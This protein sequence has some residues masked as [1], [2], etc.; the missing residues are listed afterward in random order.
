MF[1]LHIK[2]FEYLWLGNLSQ[3]EVSNKNVAAPVATLDNTDG[4]VL[5]KVNQLDNSSTLPPTSEIDIHTTKLSINSYIDKMKSKRPLSPLPM[6][7]V[8]QLY[9]EEGAPECT[10]AHLV[11]ENSDRFSYQQLLG[12]IIFWRL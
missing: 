7:C 4:S 5:N 11:L 2:A 10:I 9:A 3:E 6:D 8:E 1:K 12:E